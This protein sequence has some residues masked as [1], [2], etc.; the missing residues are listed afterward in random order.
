MKDYTKLTSEELLLEK[1][2]LQ[3]KQR[4]NQ[5]YGK[6]WKH[7][8]IIDRQYELEYIKIDQELQWRHDAEN[9]LNLNRI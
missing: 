9:Y 7:S 5:I 3:N 4:E 2:K 1:Q 6:N 8:H